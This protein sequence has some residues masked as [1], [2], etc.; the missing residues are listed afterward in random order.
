MEISD[1]NSQNHVL[2][3]EDCEDMLRTM[4]NVLEMAGFR[5]DSVM[6]GGEAI[7]RLRQSPEIELVI[8]N[9]LLPDAS[10]LSVLRRLRADGCRAAVIGTSALDVGDGFV[11]AGAVAFMEKPFDINELV[12]LCREVLAPITRRRPGNKPSEAKGVDVQPD[13]TTLHGGGSVG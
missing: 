11:K 13:R 1:A 2:L 7:A 3:V 8:L 9:F 4:A 10:G 6:T 5:V 12:G